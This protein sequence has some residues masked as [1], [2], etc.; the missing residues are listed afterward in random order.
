MDWEFRAGRAKLLHLE[1]ISIEVL[2]I[3]QHRKLCPPSWDR[4]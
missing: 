1:W 2:L 3:V 4:T